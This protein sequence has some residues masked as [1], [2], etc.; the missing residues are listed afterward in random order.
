MPDFHDWVLETLSQPIWNGAT[1]EELIALPS[2][3][4]RN[5]ALWVEKFNQL[6]ETGTQSLI[7]VYEKLQILIQSE[8][9][10]K[11]HERRNS[12]RSVGGSWNLVTLEKRFKNKLDLIVTNRKL[13]FHLEDVLFLKESNEQNGIKINIF[14]FTDLLVYAEQQ[15]NNFNI[16][17]QQNLKNEITLTPLP[18]G[19]GE[20]WSILV[21]NSDTRVTLMFQ[22]ETLREDCLKQLTKRIDDFRIGAVTKYT[23]VS[24]EKPIQNNYLKSPRLRSH[25][26]SKER[27]A[28]RSPRG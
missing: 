15:D 25:S 17:A 18:T 8:T 16:V 9:I 4:L 6:F 7:E 21:S 5:Y 26:E 13:F 28:P 11:R 19:A 3:H 2:K 24:D 12:F 14:L 27:H 20:Q 22:S 10:E 23:P 1:F